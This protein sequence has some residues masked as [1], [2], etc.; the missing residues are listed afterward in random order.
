MM[1]F[2]SHQGWIVMTDIDTQTVAAILD[3]QPGD[4]FSEMYAFF[5]IVLRR[6]GDMVT[7]MEYSPPCELPREGHIYSCSVDDFG[8]KYAYHH[9]PGYWIRLIHRGTDVS[10]LLSLES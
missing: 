5:V 7:A 1:L 4:K 6:D 3:P 10:D 9:I 8:S 2:A